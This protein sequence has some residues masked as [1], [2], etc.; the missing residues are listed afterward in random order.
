MLAFS[1]SHHR[2]LMVHLRAAN[3]KGIDF[4]L[5]LLHFLVV[6]FDTTGLAS[7][8]P[9]LKV[10]SIHGCSVHLEIQQC[11]LLTCLGDFLAVGSSHCPPK[12]PWDLGL[13][14][15]GWNTFEIKLGC[16]FFTVWWMDGGKRVT[17]N[18]RSVGIQG[19]H[20]S[21]LIGITI[22][23]PEWTPKFFPDHEIMS[24]LLGLT[25]SQGNQS[26]SP[27]S[28]RGPSSDSDY[29]DLS[30]IGK[31]GFRFTHFLLS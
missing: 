27:P 15:V 4:L 21:L 24:T 11:K 17:R 18:K 26:T 31:F 8:I 14:R 30:T 29:G 16:T 2:E 1:S 3:C 9:K 19:G 7:K 5:Y 20:Q 12:G 25:D 6:R 23:S 10:N 13:D 28:S 22:P